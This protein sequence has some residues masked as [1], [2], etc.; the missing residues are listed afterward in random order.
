MYI[1]RFN[2][3]DQSVRE[4]LLAVS[5]F[6]A[7]FAET[8]HLSNTAKLCGL[9]HDMGKYSNAFQEY[10]NE[11]KEHTIDGTYKEWIKKRKKGDHGVYGAK[12]IYENICI[13]TL[14]EK[15]TCEIISEV[16]CYHHGGLPDNMEDKNKVP[17][18][19]RFNKISDEEMKKV[20]NIYMKENSD[21]NIEDLFKKSVVEITSIYKRID[22]KVS[23]WLGLVIKHLYS[24][25][26][27]ADRLDSYLFESGKEYDDIDIETIQKLW[28]N[29]NKKLEAKLKDFQSAECK[30]PLEKTVKK[31]RQNISDNCFNFAKKPSGIYTLTVPTGGGKT[32]SSLRFALNHAIEH[33]KQRIYYIIPYTTIIEQNA[34][35]V[36]KILDCKDNL[37]EYHSNVLNS[38]KKNK[39][40]GSINEEENDD[41][42]LLTERWT[43]PIIFTTMVQ[44]LNTVYATGNQNIRRMH[45]LADSVI[46]FDEIQTLPIKCFYLFYECINYLNKIANSTI[47]LCTATQPKLDIVKEKINF[48]IDSEIISDVNKHF[49][50]LKRMNVIDKTE[51]AMSISELSDFV[52]KVKESSKSVLV[53]M[54]TVSSAENL[55]D[56]LKKHNLKNVKLYLLSTR[57]C[58]K[59]RESVIESLKKDLKNNES[60]ICVSTQL[61]EAGVD[62][63]FTSTIR[64]LAGLDS[65]AQT[66][67]RGNRHGENKIS[68]SYIVKVSEENVSALPEI[69]LGQKHTEAVL[70]FYKKHPNNYDNSLLSPKAMDKYYVDFY[71]DEDINK[72]MDYPLKDEESICY[73]LK[74][75]KKRKNRYNG[76]YPLTFSYQFETA[77]RNFEVINQ[78]TVTVIVPYDE[79][80]KEIIA[81]LKSDCTIDKKAKALKDAQKYSV[82]IYEG[83][84]KKL[85]DKHAFDTCE[86]EEISILLEGFY[87][88]KKGVTQDKELSLYDF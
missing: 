25:L 44:F 1:A 62:I 78:K 75:I 54:N 38:N 70:S 55:F 35:E 45:N 17:L 30:T 57:L 12:Y 73:L 59:H 58:P 72:N 79:K 37:L 13:K 6:C 80:A 10:I 46:I 34:S 19:E 87:S 5:K 50:E 8:V 42:E 18:L 9:L 63:S 88:E 7:K 39:K 81:T 49:D 48:N 51:N 82:N 3:K 14:D 77:R 20:I 26:V 32:L 23:F 29:Y 24:I 76:K 4:H 21:F 85:C 64:S 83:L 11:A 15:R 65:I 31:T 74:D 47:V 22:G 43:S 41:Y 33:T 16:V 60:L 40:G 53:V 69:Y 2:P 86:F 56:E 71:S 67:G 28:K 68:N 52:C 61:I 66:T 84:Y 36:R 27:D